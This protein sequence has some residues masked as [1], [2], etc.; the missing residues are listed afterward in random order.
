MYWVA[1]T[2]KNTTNGALEKRLWDAVDQFRANSDFKFR[3]GRM[4]D[5]VNGVD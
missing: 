1:P 3:N 5:C 2:E 4:G